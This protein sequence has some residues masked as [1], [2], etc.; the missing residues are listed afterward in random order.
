MQWQLQ[1][2]ENRLG[3][4]EGSQTTLSQFAL[5]APVVLGVQLLNRSGRLD[6]LPDGRRANRSEHVPPIRSRAP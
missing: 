4:D 5:T 6:S 1:K 3:A 2:V